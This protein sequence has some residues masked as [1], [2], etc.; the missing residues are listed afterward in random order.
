MI[1]AVGAAKKV[2]V[3]AAT[4]CNLYLMSRAS[5][6]H[7]IGSYAYDLEAG[8]LFPPFFC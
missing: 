5:K 7:P 2:A 8:M 3:E 6:N 4:E 1:V